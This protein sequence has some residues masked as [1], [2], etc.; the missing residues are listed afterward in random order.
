VG[1]RVVWE[2]GR[3]LSSCIVGVLVVLWDR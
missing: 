1:V 2:T 3:V